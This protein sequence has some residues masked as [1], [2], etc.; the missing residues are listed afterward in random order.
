MIKDFFHNDLVL[1]TERALLEPLTERHFEL[2]WPIAAEKDIWAFT[3]AKINSQKDFKNYFDTALQERKNKSSYPFAIYDKREKR[4]AGSTRYGN[5]SFE[6]KKVE[7]GWTW[8]HPQLQATG[9]NRACKFLLLRYG[10]EELQ[11]NRIELKTALTNI[12]SQN[13]IAKLGATK[14]GV[15]RK[16]MINDDG[17]VRDTVFFSIIDEEWPR[18]RNTVFREY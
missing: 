5:I 4:Y 17:T 9:L 16:H 7:I 11:L 15:L 13:A 1:E 14:E 10:F 18:I 2:L 6:N 8:Y 12:K 3:S